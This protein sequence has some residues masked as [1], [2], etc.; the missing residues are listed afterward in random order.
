MKD[1]VFGSAWHVKS[2]RSHLFGYLTKYIYI[3]II[4]IQ[5]NPT[6][7]NKQISSQNSTRG[8]PVTTLVGTNFV[9]P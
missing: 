3:Y 4:W 5:T 9:L 1:F 8:P 2:S 6:V 7:E